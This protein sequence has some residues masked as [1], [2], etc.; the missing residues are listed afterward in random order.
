MG[1]AARAGVP[2]RTALPV[3]VLALLEP[4]ARGIIVAPRLQPRAW[5]AATARGPAR[6]SLIHI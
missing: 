3:E 6:L 4:E 5:E 1:E 2:P